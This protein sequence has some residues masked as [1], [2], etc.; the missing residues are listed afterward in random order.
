M[1]VQ[2]GLSLG[3]VAGLALIL[4]QAVGAAPASPVAPDAAAQ[5]FA[6]ADDFKA[7]TLVDI[8]ASDDGWPV[9]VR[10]LADVLPAQAKAAALEA[11]GRP[12]PLVAA[13]KTGP[14]V[15]IIGSC[16]EFSDAES[17]ALAEYVF[18]GGKALILARATDP[19]VLRL[20][21][22]NNLLFGLDVLAIDGRA[23][24]AVQVAKHP[25]VAGVSGLS[26]VPAGVRL[27]SGKATSVASVGG[28]ALALAGETGIG[29]FVVLDATPMLDG[30]DPKANAARDAF[31]T[32]VRRLLGWLAQK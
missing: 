15:A 8:G 19:T 2:R 12:D 32:L 25:A 11:R 29:R 14:A 1:T 5:V 22:V 6:A 16:R 26:P 21:A 27:V 17:I 20:I 18:C 31:M 30:K 3:T 9:I 13:L 7:R 4:A 28:A 24:G 10:Q 23:A